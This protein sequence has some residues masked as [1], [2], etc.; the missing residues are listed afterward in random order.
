MST[1]LS[2]AKAR[3]VAKTTK[4]IMRTPSHTFAVSQAPFGI[5]PFFIAPVLAGETLKKLN[6]QSRVITDPIKNPITGWHKD[7]MFFYV[8]ASQL[9]SF[10]NFK[11]M[12]LDPEETSG[13][14]DD[15][16]YALTYH[17]G[18]DRDWLRECYDLIVKKYFRSEKE[19][20]A[21]L[22]FA[23]F[24]NVEIASINQKTWLDSMVT[25]DEIPNVV[26]DQTPTADITMEQL[27]ALEQMYQ[28]MRNAGLSDMSWEDYLAS[29]GVNVG[30]EADV[31]K[32]E[33]IRSL[34]YFSYP[35]N[36]VN[37]APVID[38]EGQVVVAAG[39]PTSA[40]SW[41]IQGTSDK[42]RYFKEPGFLVGVTVTR[43]K[44]YMANQKQ[45]GVSALTRA[46]YWLPMTDIQAPEMSLKKY[47]QAEGP[48]DPT[49]FATT[50]YAIDVRD[51]FVYGDQFVYD[52]AQSDVPLAAI[53]AARTD[54]SVFKD[55]VS[56]EDMIDFF[57][58]PA[59]TYVREDGIVSFVIAGHQADH[60]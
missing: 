37:N 55:Y 18:K 22:T 31:T 47:A 57:V 54:G 26:L 59:H 1:Y 10:D 50:G 39:Q 13:E 11:K 43:P 25:S 42:D 4:R 53:P 14:D 8:K 12:L 60:T 48:L 17:N 16:A 41:A 45:T 27:E 6:L 19:I 29:Q 40:V 23:T 58:D 49:E 30:G 28:T 20:G 3:E 52:P 56:E 44:I 15:A 9:P 51:L 5:Q 21:G 7:Y 32:P 38:S 2:P 46:R 35:T 36:T 24:D 34:R 33:L